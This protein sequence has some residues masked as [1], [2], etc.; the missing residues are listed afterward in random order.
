M[1]Q[2]RAGG[3]DSLTANL[4]RLLDEHGGLDDDL[5]LAAAHEG[6][7]S[8]VAEALGRRAGLDG[9]VAAGE[10]LS[11][12]AERLM[13]LFRLAGS[14]RPLVAGLLA[15]IGDLLG[16]SDPGRA[17]AIFDSITEDQAAAARTWLSVDS[18]YRRARAVLE[19]FNG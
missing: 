8:F 13:M 15:S 14:P 4:A 5:I 6:E 18:A 1:S 12:K 11:G 16:L 19:G 9:P 2:D 7:T 17:I 3:I 10:L